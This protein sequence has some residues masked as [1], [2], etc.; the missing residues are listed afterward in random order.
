MVGGRV[1]RLPLVFLSHLRKYS[2]GRC[3]ASVMGLVVQGLGSICDCQTPDAIVYTFETERAV[4]VAKTSIQWTESTWNPVTGCSKISA[5]CAHCYAERMALRLQSMGVAKYRA[6][7]E[8]TLHPEVLEEPLRW[9]KPRVVFVNSMSD[10]FHKRVPLRYVERVF[11]TM[12]RAPQHVFQIVTKRSQRLAE[13]S[14]HLDWPENVWMGVTVENRRSRFRIDHLRQTPAYVKWLSLEPLLEGLADLNLTGIGWV[15]VGGESGP[16]ARPMHEDWV[17][18]I[19]R[20]CQASRVPFFFKQWGGV[21]KRK[22]GRLL[23]GRTYSEIPLPEGSQLCL[24][25]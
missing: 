9:K 25:F 12:M 24:R 11:D 18:D 16:G 8:V 23:S 4:V 2:E 21:N 22:T 7:F 14:P 17:I 15:V 19:R 6:G 1:S 10:L 13:L 20:Q 5:G 3:A